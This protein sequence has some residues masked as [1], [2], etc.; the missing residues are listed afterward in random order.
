MIDMSPSAS[1]RDAMTKTLPLLAA[2]LLL[3]STLVVLPGADAQVN[4]GS[5][6][7]GDGAPASDT[8][9]G[10]KQ[11]TLTGT[12]FQ[13][14]VAVWFRGDAD[15][16]GPTPPGSYNELATGID[17][18][19]STEIKLFAPTIPSAF[20]ADCVSIVVTNPSGSGSVFNGGFD[21]TLA[22]APTISSLT[23]ASGPS[24]GGTQFVITG[25]NFAPNVV[26]LAS[27]IVVELDPGA[28]SEAQATVL[29][30][31]ATSI[32]ALAPAHPSGTV[33]LRVTNPDGQ[34][35]AI[36]TDAW[37]YTA[38]LLPTLTGVAP[39]TGS[40]VGGTVV[41][42]TGTNFAPGAVAEFAG[43]PA[44]AVVFSGP[45][46]LQVV[47]PPGADGSAGVVVINPDGVATTQSQFFYT[48]HTSSNRPRIDAVSPIDG[49]EE[50]G[51]KLTLTGANFHAFGNNLPEVRFGAT[52]ATVCVGA[53]M[54]VYGCTAPS[55]TS[56]MVITPPG[57]GTPAIVV[58]AFPSTVASEPNTIS[59]ASTAF[60]YVLDVEL[61]RP[62]LA[63]VVA[64]ATTTNG[65]N[66]ITINGGGFLVSNF[67]PATAVGQ[68]GGLPTVTIGGIP[69]V[70]CSGTDLAGSPAVAFPGCVA[71]L[72]DGLTVI[73]PPR[74]ADTAASDVK[75][76]VTNI[77]GRAVE[78]DAVSNNADDFDITATGPDPTVSG[79]AY[80]PSATSNGGNVVAITGTGFAV[81][82][83][84]LFG[85]T[86][87]FASAP[88]IVCN[89]V[90]NSPV[91]G[92]PAYGPSGVLLNVIAPGTA[93]G[94]FPATVDVVVTNPNKDKSST[95]GSP[96]Y[97]YTA[98]AP[99]PTL[100]S[101]GTFSGPASAQGGFSFVLSGT[102]FA[103]GDFEPTVTVGG[104]VLPAEHIDVTS[105][106]TL[107]VNPAPAHATGAVPCVVKNPDGQTVTLANCFTYVEAA[108]DPA[109]SN[110][111]P[112]TA[113][114]SGGTV[115]RLD[116][117]NF[118]LSSA[119]KPTVFVDGTALPAANV[120]AFDADEIFV[121]LPAKTSPGGISFN[122]VT[123]DGKTAGLGGEFSYMAEPPSLTSITPT[124]GPATGNTEVTLRGKFSTFRDG[125]P[126][127]VLFGGVPAE[128]VSITGTEI[129]VRTAGISNAAA[130]VPV[131]V[132]DLFGQ[133]TTLPSAYT[134]RASLPP[135]F[136]V[137]G[138]A[139]PPLF[140]LNGGS[141]VVVGGNGFANVAAVFVDGVEARGVFTT[142]GV[143]GKA[144]DSEVAFEMPNFADPERGRTSLG[145][146]S[147]GIINGDGQ[148]LG[149]QD[150]LGYSAS[151]GPVINS[152]T[153]TIGPAGGGT[154]VTISGANFAADSTVKVG[155][156]VC[157]DKQ[158]VSSTQIKCKTPAGTGV[159]PVEVTSGGVAVTLP[160]AFTYSGTTTGG[161]NTEGG[162]TGGGNTGG[163]NTG[164]GTTGGGTT[165]GPGG[166][167]TLTPAQLIAANKRVTVRVTWDGDQA[168]IEFDVPT[169]N[170]PA[171][172]LGAQVW[173]SNSPYTLVETL[174]ATTDEFED[175]RFV[176]DSAGASATS[177]YL[178]TLY[179]G[180]TEA[181][182]FF[183]Q[184][185]APDT[186]VYPGTSSLDTDASEGGGDSGLPT[187][188]WVL[189][190]LGL[191]FLIV[192][193]VI[194]IA[195]GRKG[196]GGAP[197][198]AGQGY[199]WEQTTEEQAADAEWDRAA[200]AAEA[201]PAGT[202]HHMKCP[203]CATTF[204]A[205][206]TKPIVTVCP[207]CG[208]KGVLR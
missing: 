189:I 132:I 2:A 177:K 106:T 15:C 63:S 127:A 26:P 23:P 54:P 135:T 24:R 178:V 197:P 137:I 85:P 89:G 154:P 11:I 38:G 199:A 100:A 74:T 123:P 168:V 142:T 20:H 67:L 86:V 141:A 149:L 51:T 205:Q 91:P 9:N 186:A 153:P 56:L 48:P 139:V 165:G 30:A 13:D 187:W 73:A 53:N 182:G 103:Q 60:T 191:L 148:T 65:G 41:T 166:T 194:L 161:G 92:C 167:P 49:T 104:V 117:A 155:T 169:S 36:F 68:A 176:D 112:G 115:V 71:P 202:T 158:V 87:T 83:L 119:S 143:T 19:S 77:D 122:V 50:G 180:A 200:P 47:A 114:T 140:S 160:N 204:T 4:I 170:L 195:R 134:Y 16:A 102:N 124:S 45:T 164:G 206:G 163:G 108:G 162:N 174:P 172:P 105:A 171:D 203:A 46:A 27:N 90:A 138:P 151:A 173:R 5:V 33:G 3:L 22:P 62:T 82:G 201:V 35:S 64:G 93:A 190:V 157:T 66:L 198:A 147:L 146:V 72:V 95:T 109:L 29:S 1:R 136:H 99:A 179:Y 78:S 21:Y 133:A 208:R 14:G 150:R 183:D 184:D 75:V 152:I 96:D 57:T 31:T 37:G 81:D 97:T 207:G 144:W 131:R 145:P 44:E 107:T 156:A 61:P 17:W 52:P 18:V 88:A 25:T 76:K 80:P 94:T 126:T 39:N 125:N 98:K 40:V 110:I 34:G 43:V 32:T 69:A 196:D 120:L 28:P 193:V 175:G 79:A 113:F 121:R 101:A 128:V 188:A 130:T 129:K 42:L 181:L 12:N 118:P 59:V 7:D 185:S 192:L 70:V 6:S 10:G 159:Q 58:D 84:P 116:G 111:V 55:A 8:T